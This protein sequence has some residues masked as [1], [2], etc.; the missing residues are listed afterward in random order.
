M[1]VYPHFIYLS[2]NEHLSCFHLLTAVNNAPVNIGVWI[3]FQD[4]AFNLLDIYPEVGLLSHMAIFFFFWLLG[5]LYQSLTGYMIY[6]HHLPFSRLRFNFDEF[7]FLYRNLLIWCRF[8]CLFL[9]LFSLLLES[10]PQKCYRGP[11]DCRI[12]FV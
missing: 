4:S 9:L 2:I 5:S 8:I 10:E 1:P 6:R 12:C 3:F 7:P 11:G